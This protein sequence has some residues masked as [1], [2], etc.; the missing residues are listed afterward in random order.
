[1]PLGDAGAG[2]AKKSQLVSKLLR[3]PIPTEPTGWTVPIQSTSLMSLS[4]LCFVHAEPLVLPHCAGSPFGFLE[5]S[6]SPRSTSRP[7]LG[8]TAVSSTLWVTRWATLSMQGSS[9]VSPLVCALPCASVLTGR[10]Y[11]HV[12]GWQVGYLVDVFDTQATCRASLAG[13]SSS[14]SSTC[15]TSLRDFEPS[16]GQACKQVLASA[17]VLDESVG[18]KAPIGGLVGCDPISGATEGGILLP[19][20][21]EGGPQGTFVKPAGWVSPLLRLCQPLLQL[22]LTS[23]LSARVVGRGA[24]TSVFGRAGRLEQQ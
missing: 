19:T 24:S 11:S 18:L 20:C 1:M 15:S 17:V 21:G 14:G 3:S 4:R 6:T 7:I 5:S 12:P 22:L 23:L 16:A 8:A 9:T 13:G 10:P 2:T